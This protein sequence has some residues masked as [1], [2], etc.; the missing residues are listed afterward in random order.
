MNYIKGFQSWL[1]FITGSEEE[2]M[3][4]LFLC[5]LLIVADNVFVFEVQYGITDSLETKAFSIWN[6]TDINFC[7]N[8]HYKL[9]RNCCQE[10]VDYMYWNPTAKQTLAVI[11]IYCFSRCCTWAG[12]GREWSPLATGMF[13]KGSF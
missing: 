9:Y 3:L 10:R 7:Q 11:G 5:N 6:E 4:K 13:G 1:P 12:C 8:L 2:L